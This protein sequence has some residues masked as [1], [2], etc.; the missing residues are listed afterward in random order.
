[1]QGAAAQG[2]VSSAANVGSSGAA[3]AP[4]G[5]ISKVLAGR[6]KRRHQEPVAVRHLLAEQLRSRVVA[7]AR[8]QRCFRA[9]LPRVQLVHGWRRSTPRWI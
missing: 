3:V 8:L 4:V 9:Q 2:T 5:A 6:H 7:L 1:A